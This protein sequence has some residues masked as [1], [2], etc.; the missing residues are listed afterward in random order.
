MG[1]AALS[2]TNELFDEAVSLHDC[3]GESLTMVRSCSGT[4]MFNL[5]RGV[6]CVAEEG[7]DPLFIAPE[8]WKPFVELRFAQDEPGFHVVTDEEAQNGVW[9]YRHRDAC[10]RCGVADQ[11]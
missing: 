5:A 1:S 10:P 3:Y 7:T 11:P 9:G 8:H 6:F 2:S 4:W